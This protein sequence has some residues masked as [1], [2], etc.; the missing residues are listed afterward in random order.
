MF[1][2]YNQLIESNEKHKLNFNIISGMT[3][4]LGHDFMHEFCEKSFHSSNKDKIIG[5]LA[6]DCLKKSDFAGLKCYLDL[7][8]E[9]AVYLG[10]V[11]KVVELCHTKNHKSEYQFYMDLSLK[12]YHE[13]ETQNLPDSILNHLLSIACKASDLSVIDLI[14]LKNKSASEHAKLISRIGE[15][16]SNDIGFCSADYFKRLVHPTLG[17]AFRTAVIQG[18]S[19][20]HI[21]LDFLTK[22]LKVNSFSSGELEYL[23]YIYGVKVIFIGEPSSISQIQLNKRNNLDWALNLKKYLSN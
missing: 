22:L 15:H 9:K 14:L 10:T 3:T 18:M 2:E 16:L 20:K 12:M 8:S 5:F 7:I 17:S 13:L 23:L 19:I 11:T 1:T 6:I 21:N 4:V